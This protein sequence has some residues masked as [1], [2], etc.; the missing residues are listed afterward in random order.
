MTGACGFAR[1][2]R[3][4]RHR[5]TR[6]GLVDELCDDVAT[7]VGEHEGLVVRLTGEA[8]IGKTT[9]ASE[10]A[11]A[12][13]A[14]G[15]EA[16]RGGAIDVA[17]AAPFAAIRTVHA[18]DGTRLWSTGG[19]SEIEASARAGRSTADAERR[20][21]REGVVDIAE[22]WCT[23]PT[24]VVLDDLHWADLASL[25]VC[26][27][28][29]QAAV[30]CPLVLV[31][32]HRPPHAGDPLARWLHEFQASGA[33]SVELDPLTSGEVAELVETL[34][35]ARPDRSLLRRV[36]GAAG[37][38]FLVR[39]FIDGLLAQGGGAVT[40]SPSGEGPLTPLQLQDAV[41]EE[42]SLL[43]DDVTRTL[44]AAS[45][46]GGPID[47][48][49]VAA[50]VGATVIDLAEPI[51]RAT[52]A[53]LLQEHDGHLRFRHDLVRQAVY[54]RMAMPLR[55]VLHRQVASILAARGAPMGVVGSHLV[56]G[57][58]ENDPAAAELLQAAAADIVLLDPIGALEFLHRAGE[59]APNDLPTRKLIERARMDALTAVGRLDEADALLHWLLGVADD[60]ERA[61]LLARRAGIA[62]VEGEPERGMDYLGQALDLAI[63]DE[64]RAP[65]L[66]LASVTWAQA[67]RLDEARE[68]AEAALAA[69][70][71]A[72]EPVGQSV[73][74]AMLGRMAAYGHD[75]ESAL[76]HGARSV[77]IADADTT[78]AAHSYVP[79]L[80][81]GTSAF[82]A[83]LLDESMRMVQRGLA[84]ADHHGFAWTRPIYSALAAAVHYRR[85]VVDE[86]RAE[87]AAAAE[88][89]E[90]M[91]SR[92]TL[93]WLHGISALTAVDQ[94]DL[95]AARSHAQ[96]GWE[97]MERGQS[98][99]GP[100]HLILAGA[101]IAQADGDD[102]GAHAWLC[103][104]WDQFEELDLHN[105]QP[106]L[107]FD[108][109]VSAAV[110]EDVAR[111]DA[112]AERLRSIAGETGLVA[113]VAL[114]EL[115]GALRSRDASEGR[116]AFARLETT[117]RRLEVAHWLAQVPD[118][119]GID[120][121]TAR[122]RAAEIFSES[123]ATAR[124]AAL[125]LVPSTDD[126][127]W[128]T[129]TPSEAEIVRLLAQG[130]TNAQIATRRG[131]S[132]RTIESHLGR[133]YRKL[134][135][136]GRVA[137][138]VAAADHFAR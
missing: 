54:E 25:D 49:C 4:A 119:I 18:A 31:V 137:L 117:E 74:L 97:L 58:I 27:G 10:L 100:D 89:A 59:C 132:R 85:G 56:L 61:E 106:L 138:T 63:D 81:Y 40:S 78:G 13:I 47:L 71:R 2:R 42:L 105:C 94:G 22:R 62:A 128:S 7:A 1:M 67:R 108:L 11:A 51:E 86:A 111:L 87:A 76:Q 3:V 17:T 50:L 53:R 14:A 52:T 43:G 109:A 6:G 65:I 82:E 44:R 24:V 39:E 98:V 19:W 38:P 121:G 91:S 92:A 113:N 120:A 115:V 96:R 21:I 23:T 130:L 26:L 20:A 75:L 73:G 129:L 88:A 83:D 131:S 29:A 69:G 16:W 5:H 110:H 35:G 126:G 84:V 122:A 68:L 9:V 33:L 93:T 114:A 60:D 107:G 101:R 15:A 125:G 135:I 30:A 70:S 57:V 104:A 133:V 34:T 95:D 32:T 79:C 90:E 102:E 41:A 134:G 103:S 12:A 112:V 118:L 45:V 66:A 77:A 124:A 8:G 48:E 136:D 64:V 46:L 55:S 80:H 36:D 99:L 72:R 28:L 116:A 123:G 37:N 127:P